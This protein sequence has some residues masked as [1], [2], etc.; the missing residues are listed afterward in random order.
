[1]DLKTVELGEI[2]DVQ[3]LFSYPPNCHEICFLQ[4]SLEETIAHY[5][6]AS[7]SRDQLDGLAVSIRTEQEHIFVEIRG[8]EAA[9]YGDLI[10]SFVEVGQLAFKASLQLSA[11]KQWRYNWRF[12]L[13]LGLAMARHRT[14]QLLHFPPDYVLGLDQYYL[15]AHTTL[16][17]AELLEANGVKSS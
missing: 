13:P 10:K 3:R 6:Q 12:F 14:V 15:S 11:E 2:E 9:E 5:L 16:R 1:M 7:I 8:K 4:Q 17:W